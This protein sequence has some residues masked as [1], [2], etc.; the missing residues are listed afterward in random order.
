MKIPARNR[1]LGSG[2]GINPFEI[3]VGFFFFFLVGSIK[4]DLSDFLVVVVV[5]D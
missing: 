2:K 5:D 1:N 3:L 4:C